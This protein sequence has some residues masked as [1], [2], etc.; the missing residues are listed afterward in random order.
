MPVAQTS[1]SV[2]LTE[3]VRGVRSKL[4]RVSVIQGVSH[5][6]IAVGLLLGG[7]MALD[8]AVN[9]PASVRGFLLLVYLGAFG[10][11]AWRGILK[12]LFHQ[13][14][15]DAVALMVERGV[16]EFRSRLI[17]SLQLCRAGLTPGASPILVRR[18]VSETEEIAR[19]RNF[20][21]VVSV[22]KM[23][24][25]AAL[26]ILLMAAGGVLF[27]HFGD[28]MIFLNRAML[29]GEAYPFKTKLELKE[30]LIVVPRGENV[31]I[32]AL[33]RGILPEGG[34]VYL[35]Y[36]DSAD[37]VEREFPRVSEAEGTATYQRVEENVHQ[38]FNFEVMVND[39]RATGRVEVRT[40]PQVAA[41]ACSQHFPDYTERNATDRVVRGLQIG[42]VLAG[43]TLDFSVTP[44]R[45]LAFALMRIHY[46]DGTERNAT[47]KIVPGSAR[48]D[49]GHIEARLEANNTDVQS[50]SF[51]MKA[52]DDI[53]SLD[54]AR[55]RFSI[56]PD[57][58]PEVALLGPPDLDQV[59]ARA[60]PRLRFEI[61]DDYGLAKLEL[62]YR[63]G[64]GPEKSLPVDH[65]T[66][67]FDW[68]F[69]KLSAQPPEGSLVTYRLVATDNNNI[70]GPGVGSSKENRF[71]IVSVLVKEQ[72]LLKRADRVVNRIKLTKKDQDLAR[73]ELLLILQQ[74]ARLRG[75]QN[76]SNNG[77]NRDK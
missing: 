54:E 51:Y 38:S 14:G 27:N 58:P 45:P 76:P 72:A 61:S 10:V 4:V 18:L 28:S 75:E 44:T 3:R 59:T 41:L 39:G 25:A 69:L 1:S 2:M 42:T 43:S 56:I 77:Q 47:A 50:V 22:D 55:Y 15:D 7:G 62:H 23:A 68:D 6:A 53:V 19:P 21:E 52:T 67:A 8:W 16:P 5:V 20:G 33:A 64:E 71:E 49:P 13:P 63:V 17:A 46:A 57:Q 74:I 32:T 26:A 12:P 65:T 70:T 66:T 24:S 30:K 73:E 40:R 29:G 35:A 34:Q 37:R 9:L 48:D 36:D 31:T 11:L 60:F